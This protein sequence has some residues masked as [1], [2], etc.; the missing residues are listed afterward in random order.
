MMFASSQGKCSINESKSHQV[1][2][3]FPCRI[4][5]LK[6]FCRKKLD[7]EPHFWDYFSTLIP[8]LFIS[9]QSNYHSVWLQLWEVQYLFLIGFL[10]WHMKWINISV[11]ELE[12]I[13][14]H[15]S[16]NKMKEAVNLVQSL[17]GKKSNHHETLHTQN[18]LWKLCCFF[19][20][21]TSVFV[22]KENQTLD[23]GSTFHWN[24]LNNTFPS[25][26]NGCCKYQMI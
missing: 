18:R 8:N 17:R 9:F 6:W 3:V 1:S 2:S 5:T 12:C 7:E 16:I 14:F 21:Y 24:K 15:Y 20:L 4:E 13:K 22:K 19:L 23:S 10:Y 11:S 25:T 26:L